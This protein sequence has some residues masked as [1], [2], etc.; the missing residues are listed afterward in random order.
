MEYFWYAIIIVGLL[1]LYIL[2]THFINVNREKIIYEEIKVVALKN[3]FTFEKVEKQKYDCILRN[4]EYDIYLKICKIPSNS[5]I[6]IN[7]KETWCL[8]WGGK[9]VGRNYPNSRYLN[10]LI[11]F[12]K[13]N[14]SSEDKNVIR[15]VA[16][17]P[18]CEVILKYL[19][20]SEIDT[21]HPYNISYGFK[22]IKYKELE[23]NFSD[24]LIFKD[25]RK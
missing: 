22:A 12:L 21:V 24:L 3:N 11:P 7:S 17:Y 13:S 25:K 16:F 15:V 18:G 4:N 2:I 1:V 23:T 10:E 9:R 5:S 14:I 19:N 20:E 8:R 6:T